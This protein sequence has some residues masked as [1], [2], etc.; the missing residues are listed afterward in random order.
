MKLIRYPLFFSLSA[1][2]PYSTFAAE[3]A[4]LEQFFDENISQQMQLC[5]VC[6]IP[7]G[8]A[9]VE[10]GDGFL[11]YPD[12]SEY[13]NFYDAW[14]LLGE[15]VNDNPL[16]TMNSDPAL[17]HT[18]F[19]N[20]PTTSTIYANVETL[21]TCWDL[22]EACPIITTP[23]SAD[24]AVSMAGNNGQNNDGVIN[25]AITVNN[26]GPDTA[27][28]LEIVH[29][30]P[31]QVN[32]SAVSPSSIAYTLEGDDVILYLDSLTSGSNQ[33]IDLSV[34]TATTNNTLMSFTSSVS[35]LTQDTNLA[36]NSTTAQ[37]GG[38]VISNSADLLISMTGQNGKNQNGS[39]NYS[40]TVENAGPSNATD[41]VI[42][43]QIPTPVTL[44][45]VS[46][47]SIAYIASGNEITFYLDALN[48]GSDQNIN[49]TVTTSTDNNDKMDFSAEVS[50]STSDPNPANNASTARFGGSL[51]WFLVL[52]SGLLLA[53][54]TRRKG[55]RTLVTQ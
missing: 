22:P 46:P 17:N 10:G 16:L 53:I 8:L 13:Q 37:F 3:S 31:S 15:G 24:L 47:S 9:D 45:S 18:G 26:A 27:N 4:D 25:Y 23:D 38:G 30:L 39:I 2:I 21:L 43:H 42:T 7:N 33:T 11:L 52:L 28:T 51:D 14:V 35:A 54:R 20:W 36:N 12:Q 34:T 19:Q 29:Q 6:H 55:T 48:S 5:G 40:I 1:V 32:L 41:L 44:S 50:A 49:L